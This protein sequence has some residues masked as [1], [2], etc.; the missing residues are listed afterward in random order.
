MKINVLNSNVGGVP[1]FGA[2]CA[3]ASPF[4]VE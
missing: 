1:L 4:P 3:W 2:G